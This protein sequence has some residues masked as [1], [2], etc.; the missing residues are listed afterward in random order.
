MGFLMAL[1]VTLFLNAPLW[2]SVLRGGESG[3]QTVAIE[4]SEELLYLARV[5]ETVDG[6]P[7]AGQPFVWELRSQWYPAGSLVEWLVGVPMRLGLTI[8]QTSMLADFFGPLLL[9]LLLWFG[10]R[11][12]IA[13]RGWRMSLVLLVFAGAGHAFWKRP[14]HP[15]TNFVL[16]L[17]YIALLLSRYRDRLPLCAARSALAGVM[18]YTY[19]YHWTYCIAAESCMAMMHIAMTHSR[20]QQWLSIIALVLPFSVV[21]AP[22][23]V[24]SLPMLHTQASIDIAHRQGVLDSRLPTAPLLQLKL[25]LLCAGIAYTAYRERTMR[26]FLPLF[27]L[28][29]AGFIVFNQAMLTGKELAFSSHYGPLVDIVIAIAFALILSHWCQKRW[30]RYGVISLL[31][32]HTLVLDI[33]LMRGEFQ[34]FARASLQR[35][36]DERS[37]VQLGDVPGEVVIL[38]PLDIADSIP[39]Y[40]DDYPLLSGNTMMSPLTDDELYARAALQEDL[41]GE[42]LPWSMIVGFG[43]SHTQSRDRRLCA[44][45]R[46]LGRS[47]VVPDLLEYLPERWRDFE[48]R[49]SAV[50]ADI[51]RS[52]HERHV[53]ALVLAKPPPW[54]EPMLKPVRTVGE[55]TLYTWKVEEKK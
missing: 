28:M 45:I 16:P 26:P 30:L 20:R 53:S 3:R 46:L 10:V 6:Y 47:C 36:H 19:P 23:L 49:P 44:W 29:A 12:L 8:K 18:L 25:L 4:S 5:R 27:A 43:P 42:K 55:Y 15:Q 22:W 38:A 32:L 17:T 31:M 1:G 33:P 7:S 51:L 9:V 35:D 50:S 48:R 52:L 13:S 21:A 54:L 24:W 40:T 34:A 11:P 37:I 14:I 2:T 39:V 41:T